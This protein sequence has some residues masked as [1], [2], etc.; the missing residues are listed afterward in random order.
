MDSHTLKCHSG[1]DGK[2]P[3]G[4][5]PRLLL[6]NDPGGGMVDPVPATPEGTQ[7]LGVRVALAPLLSALDACDAVEIEGAGRA[8]GHGQRRLTVNRT[9][10]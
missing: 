5:V 7:G 6:V 8:D 10:A 9:A 2:V 1:E 3:Q 4:G